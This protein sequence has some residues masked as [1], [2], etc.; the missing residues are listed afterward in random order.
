MIVNLQNELEA[1]RGTT[2]ENL[3]T[4]QNDLPHSLIT[5]FIDRQHPSKQEYL[6]KL[7]LND[8]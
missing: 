1:I 2:I 5:G 8:E 3:N 4:F 6:P 7:L